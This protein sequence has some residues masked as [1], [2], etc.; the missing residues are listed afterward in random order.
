MDKIVEASAPVTYVDDP[1]AP[2]VYASNF[3]G[4]QLL[5]GNAIVTLESARADHST[6]PGA[7][8]RVVVARIVMPVAVAQ[9]LALQLNSLLER[10][11]VAQLSP[12]SV[13]RT[14]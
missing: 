2:E 7:I 6:T 5:M 13:A 3:S 10:G 11:A 8:N 9:S 12:R 1:H 4:I 14:Q